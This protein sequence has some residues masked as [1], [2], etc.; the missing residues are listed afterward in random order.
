MKRKRSPRGF[1]LLELLIVVVILGVLA[2]LAIPQYLK[3][4]ER[5]RGSEAFIHLDAIRMA[6]MT[7]YAQHRVYTTDFSLLD[8]DNPNLLPPPPVGKRLFNYSIE[9]STPFSFTAT[10]SRFRLDGVEEVVTINEFG[11]L[12]RTTINP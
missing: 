6:E 10:A 1:T 7:Y 9:T 2:G 12:V 8:I 3:T 11:R 5:S 4:V